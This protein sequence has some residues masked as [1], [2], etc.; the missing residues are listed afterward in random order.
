M[1]RHDF[2]QSWVYSTVSRLRSVRLVPPPGATEMVRD[3]V[4]RPVRTIRAGS[5]NAFLAGG[6]CSIS[7]LAAHSGAR[8]DFILVCL[9][10]FA[11]WSHSRLVVGLSASSPSF[12]GNGSFVAAE[13]N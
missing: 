5:E 10:L 3:S 4:H 6:S 13:A 1:D 9:A 7:V 2:V 12:A 8:G 11:A